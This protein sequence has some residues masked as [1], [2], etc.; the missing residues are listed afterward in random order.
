M[1]ETARVWDAK[2]GA[3]LATLSGHTGC[4]DQRG[5]QPG[6]HAHRHRIL[7]ET[8]RVWDAKTGAALATLSGHTGGVTQRGVQPGRQRASSPHPTT[9][10]RAC[11]TPR[12]APRSP[13]SRGTRV[14]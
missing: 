7:D 13:R 3:A 6:R 2:T 9:R 1:D 5:V 14:G 12:P 8:A 4:G 10:P 11:G